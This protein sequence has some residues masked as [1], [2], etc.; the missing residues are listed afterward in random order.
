MNLI[1]G[2][3]I[4][5]ELR[6]QDPEQRSAYDRQID[7]AALFRSLGYIFFWPFAL[8]MLS[9]YQE[10]NKQIARVVI[11]TLSLVALSILVGGIG[12]YIGF[13]IIIL[14]IQDIAVHVVHWQHYKQKEKQ[15]I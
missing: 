13:G 12:G 4:L 5:R 1:L 6:Y 15:D 3:L 14:I 2:Y 7:G 11:I 10:T 9:R 8:I